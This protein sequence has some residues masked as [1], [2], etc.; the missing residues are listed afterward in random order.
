MT[1]TATGVTSVV[2]LR[3]AVTAGLLAAGIIFGVLSFYVL[4][5][6]EDRSANSGFHNVANYAFDSIK[7]D[8]SEK[9]STILAMAKNIAYCKPN[10]T[11]WP[12]VLVEG[13][14]DSGYA[15]R[16]AASLGT[17]FFMPLVSPEKL[18]SFEDF[19][20]DYYAS[21]PEVADEGA[22][23]VFGV[24]GNGEVYMETNGTAVAYDSPNAM[25][26][27]ISQV[28][29]TEY[30]DSSNMLYNMHS[31]I[32]YGPAL[33]AIVECSTHHNYSTASKVCSE[34]TSFVV[35]PLETTG[36]DVKFMYSAFMQPIYLERNSSKL[37]GFMGGGFDW[38][39][40]LTPIF[41][42]SPSGIEIVVKSA[43]VG[44]E[45]ATFMSASDGSVRLTKVE[46][47]H[48]DRDSSRERTLSIF[49]SDQDVELRVAYTITLYPTDEF[50]SHY[51]TSVPIYAAVGSSLLIAL[52]AATFFLY[53]YYMR[54]AS[55]V[56][57]AVLETKRRFVRFISHEIRTPLNAVHLGLE[58]LTAELTRA[59]EQLLGNCGADPT[60]MFADL[61]NNWL[62]LSAELISNSESAVDV[63]NDLLNYDKVEMGTLRLE[64]SAVPIWEVVKAAT[65]SFLTP[66]KHKGI[67]MSLSN[68]LEVED[69]F[70]GKSCH[71]PQPVVIGDYARLA[72]VMRNLISNALKFTPEQGQVIIKVEKM[73]GGLP[74]PSLV[75]SPESLHLL[76]QPRAGSICI[77]VTD[78]GVGLTA[79]QLAQICTEGMQFNANEL[80]AGKGSGLGLF[81]TKGIVEQHG[82]TLTVTSPGIGEGTCFTVEL[83]LFHRV[84]KHPGANAQ[85]ARVVP[86]NMPPLLRAPTAPTQS[87][88]SRNHSCNADYESTKNMKRIL[89][90]D[91]ASS[92]RKMLT[93]VL[94][95]K[96]YDCVQAEDGQQA[97]DR[98]V[99][100]VEA[101]EPFYSIIMDFEMPVMNGPT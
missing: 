48:T 44:D 68:N 36:S 92:N 93:R 71:Q 76:D 96:G 83:P 69:S 88:F 67:H 73:A 58:A 16:D 57:K 35:L 78:S 8:M 84:S 42:T 98:Y 4:S 55:A 20:N 13:F 64:F 24:D 101:H 12:N 17:V 53:D 14:Y 75:L 99:E 29:F 74:N 46:T 87:F 6:Y 2:V 7:Q 100:S 39:T 80:Q 97:I 91:D 70:E 63:L 40:M 33:D 72:Q 30:I 62:E 82:G 43:R 54:K 59:V 31:G 21:E 22:R 65:V 41:R 28:L 86:D 61:L 18:T 89:V 81:I 26:A 23:K 3:S 27:P 51:V 19:M 52:C 77:S 9:D 66:A 47:S 50:H 79:D 38:A 11:E 60:T 85:K 45:I 34:L 10:A 1:K 37:V 95:S 25:I 90:V 5:S 94:T 56:N 15:H 32:D 49:A